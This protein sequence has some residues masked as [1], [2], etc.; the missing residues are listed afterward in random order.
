MISVPSHAVRH[1]STAEREYRIEDISSVPNGPD[2][3]DL[4]KEQQLLLLF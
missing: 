1:I 3:D 2:I 4:K